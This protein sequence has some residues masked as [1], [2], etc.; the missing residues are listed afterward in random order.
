[1]VRHFLAL[2]ESGERSP[3]EL[4][5]SCLRRIAETDPHVLAW[6]AVLPHAEPASGPLLGLPF[7]AKDI[8][9]TRALPTAYGS[10][11]Y[12]GRHAAGQDPHLAL[13]LL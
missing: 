3:R 2:L 7:G 6:A 13:R 9:E 1:L 4:V 12:A 5:A 10:P 8:F 11:L